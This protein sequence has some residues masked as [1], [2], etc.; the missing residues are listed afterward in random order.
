MRIEPEKDPTSNDCRK[1]AVMEEM[2]AACSRKSDLPIQAALGEDMEDVLS[3][4]NRSFGTHALGQ[5]D[6]QMKENCSQYPV[7]T[8]TYELSWPEQAICCRHKKMRII[9][10]IWEQFLLVR[11]VHA[12]RE[13]EHLSRIEYL[14]CIGGSMMIVTVSCAFQDNSEPHLRLGL[15]LLTKNNSLG[16]INIACLIT[17]CR[18]I[19]PHSSHCA[20]LEFRSS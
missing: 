20:L 15:F 4:N 19:A 5:D 9:L 3:S 7:A 17:D 11:P 8:C 14:Q 18:A 16:F 6:V 1:V 10:Q 13:F 12:D 2:T